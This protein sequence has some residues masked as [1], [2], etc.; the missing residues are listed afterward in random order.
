MKIVKVIL[1]ILIMLVI[2]IAVY[3][4][5]PGSPEKTKFQKAMQK[6]SDETEKNGEVCSRQVEEIDG[7]KMELGWKCYCDRYVEKNGIKTATSVKS[8]KIFPDGRELVY[9]DAKDFTVQYIK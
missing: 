8:T 2:C 9:F 3:W 4:K 7:V 1:L 6:K 5:L